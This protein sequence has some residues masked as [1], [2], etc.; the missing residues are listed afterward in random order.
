MK[1]ILFLLVIF[2]LSLS[3]NLFAEI[4]GNVSSDIWTADGNF[5]LSGKHSTYNNS[6]KT[7]HSSDSTYLSFNS[8]LLEVKYNQALSADFSLAQGL[9]QKQNMS[10]KAYNSAGSLSDSSYG[11]AEGRSHLGNQVLYFGLLGKNSEAS[12][13]LDVGVGYLTLSQN[14]NYKNPTIVF[15]AMTPA[16]NNMS[17]TETWQKYRIRAGGASFQLKEQLKVNDALLLKLTLGYAPR[18]NARYVSTHLPN[19]AV[20]QQKQ[21]HFD[22]DGT[23]IQYDIR[24]NYFFTNRFSAILG[25]KYISIKT[26][27]ES[28]TNI[29]PMWASGDNDMDISAKGIIFGLACSF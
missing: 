23:A 26:S 10:V 11:K 5:G 13:V 9:I 25:Y 8:C 4:Q 27:G 22:S 3:V 18:V 1:S 12:S 14:I 29:Y 24:M 17:F 2:L 16:N 21:E 7:K 6:W 15:D 28:E 19:R 20:S